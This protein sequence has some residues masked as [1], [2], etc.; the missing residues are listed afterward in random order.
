MVFYGILSRHHI[1]R[2][3][4]LFVSLCMLLAANI[5]IVVVVVIIVYKV[6]I[7]RNEMNN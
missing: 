2:L 5:T 6:A 1:T 4:D 3:K 7:K